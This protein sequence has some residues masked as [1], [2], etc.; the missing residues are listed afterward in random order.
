MLALGKWVLRHCGWDL[1]TG[2]GTGT[3]LVYNGKVGFQEISIPP[4]Q[5]VN[6]N[7]VGE[8]GVLKAKIFKGM[9]D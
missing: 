3:T 1:A 4:P 6:G 9:Y 8:G 7:S 5:R 2:T